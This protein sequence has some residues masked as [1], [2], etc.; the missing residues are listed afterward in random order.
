M[1]IGGAGNDLV[2]GGP[3][4]DSL[5]GDF[6]DCNALGCPTGADRIVA[7][8]GEVDTI[9]CGAGADQAQVDAVDVVSSDA[10]QTCESVDRAAAPAPPGPVDGGG[11]KTTPASPAV[12][13]SAKAVAGRRRFRL[14]LVLRKAAT[15]T[16]TV[17]RKGAKKAL[18]R[19]SFRAKKGTVRRTI[20]K[21]GRRRIGRGT[22]RVVVKVGKTT[23]TFTVK[24][25]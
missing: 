7:R 25:K 2:D 12:L 14:T 6:R 24:V 23:R 4:T 3:G 9:S 8:D 5:F 1:L 20:T 21:V 22:Y 17:T 10:F 18:G 15:V 19:T 11:G 16:V 13:A